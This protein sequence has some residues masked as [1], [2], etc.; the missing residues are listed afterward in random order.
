M[1]PRVR[2]IVPAWWQYS[3]Y[4]SHVHMW[5]YYSCTLLDY[6]VRLRM[7]MK[8]LCGIRPG[9]ADMEHWLRPTLKSRGSRVSGNPP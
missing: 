1:Y 4:M 7:P 5:M 9:E 2:V 3:R 6:T 8:E